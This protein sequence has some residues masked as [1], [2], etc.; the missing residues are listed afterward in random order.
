M[1]HTGINIDGM[2]SKGMSSIDS[3]NSSLQ[4]KMNSVLGS[5]KEIKNEDLIMMQFEM[6]KY[7]TLITALNNTVQSAVNQ[8]KDLAKSIH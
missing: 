3:M 5:G 1:A 4:D 2:L 6:G 7:Q 8:T